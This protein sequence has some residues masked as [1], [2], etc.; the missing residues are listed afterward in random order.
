MAFDG[1]FLHA[2]AE[3]IKSN[4]LDGHLY[5][6]QQ[7][8]ETELLLTFKVGAASRKLLI[9]A[10]PSLPLICLTDINKESPL[11]APNFLMVLRKHLMNAKLK[12]VM[13]P[14]LERALVFTFDHIDEMGDPK[15]K[16]LHCELMGRYS[17]LILTDSDDTIIDSIKRVPPNLSSVRTVLPG[18]RYFLPEA[19]SKISIE[20]LTK[21]DF[22][23][24]MESKEDPVSYSAGRFIGFSKNTI[25]E[26]LK[27]EN[28]AE[29]LWTMIENIRSKKFSPTAV[30]RNGFGID[31]SAFPM[32]SYE[33]TD[34]EIRSYESPSLLLTEFFR[35]RNRELQRKARTRD[36]EKN[37]TI[38]TER[39]EKTLNLQE[40]QLEDTVDR[41]R[42]R[43]FGDLLK[44]YLY[45]LPNG[46]KS[47]TVVNYEDNNKDIVIPLD[48]S[49][50]ITENAARY[51]Q[52]YN[53]LKRT[54]E[55][56]TLQIEETKKKLLHLQLIAHSLTMVENE[57][58]LLFI[59]SEL[60]NYGFLKKKS[61]KKTRRMPKQTPY[62]FL[63][64]DGF[65]IYVGKNNLQNEEL[66]FKF[67]TGN[68]WFFH[69]KKITGSHVIVKTEGKELSDIALK[70]AASLAAYFSDGREN[71][72]TEVDYVQK[73]EVKK[74]NGGPPGLVIYHTNRSIMA[75]PD[76]RDIQRIPD[77]RN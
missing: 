51:F 36:L 56:L 17:N 18:H 14:K 12:S 33:G 69:V 65:H 77:K 10:N 70:N 19:Q 47:V 1:I 61:V 27:K 53:K 5:K 48:P 43:L 20:G 2:V 39:A 34:C 26:V 7:T 22:L 62:H 6:I 9:S 35:E 15:E 31:F 3:E 75:V 76:I 66:T 30:F 38:L 72:K 55:A 52:K 28:P 24:E 68:D 64:S 71:D 32:V 11:L 4:L 45:C 16:K 29:S 54:A 44:A 63:T 49:K 13:Q 37:V 23:K 42:F 58:D 41:D 67:A 73:K 8:E 25:K 60:E 74:V 50:S 57:D 59:R 21:E 46:E 40:K